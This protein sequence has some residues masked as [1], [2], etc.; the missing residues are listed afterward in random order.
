MKR[1]DRNG[2]AMLTKLEGVRLKAYKDL[3]GVWTIGYG[4]TATARPGMK[5]TQAEAI[6]LL[7]R[8]VERFEDC[9]AENVDV[10]LTQHQYNA[11][12]SYAFNR[13]CG[14]F[15]SSA[16]YKLI[17]TRQFAQAASAWLTSAVTVKGKRASGLVR[18]RKVEVAMFSG[19][20][21]ATQ[22]GNLA[23]RS[24]LGGGALKAVLGRV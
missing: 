10:A 21:K 16:L 4:H 13:G 15:R 19:E 18:R 5:I 8:D 14:G 22:Q 7:E 20:A 17:N 12:I 11:I 9:I 23:L 24:W 2:L 3:G 1:L 6:R